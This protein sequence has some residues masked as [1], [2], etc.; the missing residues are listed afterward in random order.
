MCLSCT[1][2]IFP[3]GTLGTLQGT[4]LTTVNDKC[5]V[6]GSSWEVTY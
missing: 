4:I 5:Y 6:L 2:D 3:K 1:E